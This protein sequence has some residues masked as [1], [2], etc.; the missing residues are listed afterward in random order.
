M[1]VVLE[2]IEL[3]LREELVY[4]VYEDGLQV[5]VV[6]TDKCLKECWREAACGLCVATPCLKT[7]YSQDHTAV[8]SFL[9]GDSHYKG[10]TSIAPRFQYLC[11]ARHM[12]SPFKVLNLLMMARWLRRGG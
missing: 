3:T 9:K 7:N 8:G 10:S 5:D 2:S 11:S 12:G 6:L 1:A 4:K